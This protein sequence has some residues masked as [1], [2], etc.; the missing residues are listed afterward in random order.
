MPPHDPAEEP[1]GF[2]T[3]IK[4]TLGIR[5]AS[6]TAEAG[7]GQGEAGRG[8]A[9]ATE[10]TEEAAGTGVSGTTATVAGAVAQPAI[11][12]ENPAFEH[13]PPGG[14]GGEAAGEAPTAC[15]A[16][17]STTTTSPPAAGEGQGA[18]SPRVEAIKLL[19]PQASRLRVGVWVPRVGAS[20]G[21]WGGVVT[22]ALLCCAT[23]RYPMG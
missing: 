17:G 12:Y 10:G 3:K 15:G 14:A 16:A 11:R 22:T 19:K 21:P 7:Q 2:L 4:A 18:T 13:E 5:P 1:T 23:G 8:G 20:A 9:A 6:P